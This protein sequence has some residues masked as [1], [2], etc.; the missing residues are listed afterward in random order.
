M[1]FNDYSYND[2]QF[3]RRCCRCYPSPPSS[4]QV[5]LPHHHIQPSGIAIN[6][7]GIGPQFL[8]EC[9]ASVCSCVC[10]CVGGCC[11]VRVCFCLVLVIVWLAAYMCVIVRACAY[12]RVAV[13]VLVCAV[14]VL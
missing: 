11:C 2:I 1:C 6:I 8:R 13:R 9:G 3:S 4:A 7:A 10:V 12:E 5:L 14:S